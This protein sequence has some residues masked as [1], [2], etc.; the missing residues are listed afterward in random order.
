MK[1]RDIQTIFRDINTVHGI[2]ELKLCKGN[3]LPFNAVKDHQRVA[4]TNVSCST[5]LFFKIP[6]S[7]IFAG[8]K[9]RFSVLKPFDCFALAKVPAYVVICFYVPRQ[10]KKFFYIPI[11]VFVQ[12]EQDSPRKS[13]TMQRAQEISYTVLE[14]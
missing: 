10:Y 6:D 1:E 13:L 9:Q 3:A 8:S 5:G 14:I 12:E 7:P 4:L 2:F 11:S